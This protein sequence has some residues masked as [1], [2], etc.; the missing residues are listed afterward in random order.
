[1]IS[2]P[3]ISKGQAVGALTL[4]AQRPH[5]IPQPGLDLL[6]AIGQQIGI[7]VENA[8][9]YRETEYLAEH[10]TL[11]HQ[12]SIILTST[13]EP[14][15]IYAQIT[16]LAAK[17]LDCQV[18]S[19]FLWDAQRQQAS[20][21]AN[22]S[23]AW[24][25]DET[26]DVPPGE[27][28]MLDNLTSRQRS[29]AIPD[30][31]SDARVP[32]VWRDAFDIQAL[33][34]LPLWTKSKPLGFLYLI[35]Q[36]APRRW[37]PDEII[38]A[39]SFANRAA[40]ALENAHLHKQVERAAALEERQRIA[41]DMHDGLAQT[42]GY[43]G[44]KVDR[45]T[46]LIDI[47]RYQQAVG[48]LG[49]IRDT[50]DQASRE[51]RLSI[52][53]LQESPPPRRPLQTLLNEIV[54][55]FS[56]KNQQPVTL[57]VKS[58]APLFLSPKHMEQISRMVQ[59]ALLNAIRHA[60]AEQIT[61]LMEKQG[62]AVTIIVE[63]NGR[64]FDPSAPIKNGKDHFGLRIMRARAARIGGYAKVESTPGQGTRVILSWPL[65]TDSTAIY[66]PSNMQVAQ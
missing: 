11:L 3:L 1:M 48:E 22:Y 65:S 28:P 63:D 55:E 21:V 56:D 2:T 24:P 10:L 53:S 17:L 14:A 8:R 35:D 23:G 59:E 12:A 13:L 58:Q 20:N 32:P 27:V 15:K 30:A 66:E 18:T 57:Q 64:G 7:A 38:L 16:A 40:I 19:M 39:Q 47:A 51:V 25:P 33:L 46:D 5:A 49:T 41:A 43:M 9:L 42:L 50:I 31:R 61:V 52:A 45:V 36:R 60:E 54:H 6:T 37:R 4:G 26:L 29:I 34:C 62:N 44:L